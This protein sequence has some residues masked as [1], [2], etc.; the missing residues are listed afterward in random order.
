MDFNK[1]IIQVL[2]RI[3]VSVENIANKN[4]DDEL[5][6][7]DA[8]C[9][10]WSDEISNLIPIND[11]NS[12]DIKLLHGIDSIKDI[13]IENTK[14]FALGYPANNAL[15]WGARGMGKS[16][17]I[18]AVHSLLYDNNSEKRLIFRL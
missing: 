6:I 4:L 3:A 12:I 17:V 7:T 18:K 15:L 16:S 2:K 9:Y 10:I 1:E 11:V 5:I 13:L 8:K 14:N